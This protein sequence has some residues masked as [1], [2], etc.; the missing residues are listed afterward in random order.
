[1]ALATV[2]GVKPVNSASAGDGDYAI[3][4]WDLTTADHTGDSIAYPDYADR[5]AQF[6]SSSWG[7]AT[8][9]I[10]GSLDGGTTWFIL[11]DPQGNVISKTANGGEA[12][13]EAVPLI[14]ARLTVVGA[15]AIVT[16]KL[17]VRKA[18]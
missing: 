1:M 11:T 17:Y 6:I 3:I 12:V 18:K 13:T 14:R 8:A 2:T 7:A 16:V 4:T 5:T 10:E 9:S 15:G